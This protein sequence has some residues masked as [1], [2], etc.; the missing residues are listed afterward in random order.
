MHTN[1]SDIVMNQTMGEDQFHLL[2]QITKEYEDGFKILNSLGPNSLTVYGGSRVV[3]TDKA[4]EDIHRVCFELAKKDWT[5][6][7]G[8]GPGIMT[9]A[10]DGAADA[11]G[12]AVSFCID[13]PGEP[14]FKDTYLSYTFKQFSVR[15][16]FL[17]QSD[18]FIVAPGGVGTLDELMELITLKSTNK[19]PNKKIILYDREFWQGYID[20]IENILLN[21]RK[22]VGTNIFDLFYV[23]NT[24]E[25]VFNYLYHDN[26]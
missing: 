8:G 21:E 26:S 3:E 5:I 15:K 22:V 1:I 23:A 25:E 11:K 6:I 17:R 19:Y 16:Y 2:K 20:W 9:A 4:F 24:P 14:P 10:L 18:V 7:T 13:I 12:Q